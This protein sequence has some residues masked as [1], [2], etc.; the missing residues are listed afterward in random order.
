MSDVAI[1]AVDTATRSRA[2]TTDQVE[3][4][5][6]FAELYR[7]YA[8]RVRAL[9]GRRLPG[10]SAADDVVQ[11]TFLRAYRMYGSFDHGRPP[12]PLLKAIANNI[13]TDMLRSPRSW[14]EES[15]P[16]AGVD[17][18]A[19][20]GDP[21]SE[22][23]AAQ[24]RGGIA[25]A[26]ASVSGRQ[27]RVLILKDIEGWD[28]V[29]VAELEGTSVESV[30]AVLKRARASFR[31]NYLALAA[32]RGLFGAAVF[33]GLRRIA[34]V[35]RLQFVT[36]V[37]SVSVAPLAAMVALTLGVAVGGV[38]WSLMRPDADAAPHLDSASL[39]VVH[40][41]AA[42]AP[43]STTAP[44]GGHTAPAAAVARGEAPAVSLSVESPSDV[45]PAQV[46]IGIERESADGSL[47]ADA[48][49]RID[50]THSFVVEG[51]VRCDRSQLRETACDAIEGALDLGR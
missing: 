31:T 40:P 7:L 36:P 8:P 45:A 43:V 10:R 23:V 14:S 47:L 28:T 20:H 33:L 18:I 44:T 25:S 2:G 38:T 49:A 6:E 16:D 17:G 5:R 9:A 1:A 12:W 30:K 34:R 24:R 4:D 32:E 42:G 22:F 15:T 48:A 46:G 51:T 19:R 37:A 13:C 11:E 35:R 27:R 39:S 29:D 3:L 50:Q 21:D 26:L 41:G